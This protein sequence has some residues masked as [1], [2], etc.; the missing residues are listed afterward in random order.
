MDVALKDTIETNITPESS[1][2]IELL[3]GAAVIDLLLNPEFQKNIDRLFEACP[4]ATIFQNRLYITAWYQVYQKKHL[5]ILVKGEVNGHLIG[6]LPVVLLHTQESDKHKNSNRITGAG[7]YDAEYQTWLAI[8]VY[9]ELFIREAL[10]KLI[11][12]FP[13]NPISFRYLPPQ[14]PLNWVKDNNKWRSYSIVQ[15]HSRPLIKLSEPDHA[16]L[17]ESKQFKN[18]LNRLKRLGEVRLEPITDPESFKNHL[19]ELTVLYDFRFGALFNKQIFKDDPV[20]KEFLLELFRLQLLHA[21]ILKVNGEIFAAVIAIAGKGWLHLSGFTCHSPFKARSYSPGLLHFSFLAKKLREEQMQYLDLTPGYDSYK[22][23]LANM[24]DEVHELVIS[25]QFTYR[26]KKRIKKWVQV[27]LIT[28]GIR[29]MT[30]EL[31]LK[32]YFYLL[33]NSNIKTVLKKISKKL[34]SNTLQKRYELKAQTFR[35]DVKISLQKNNLDHLMKYTG[36]K[37]TGI[38]RWEFLADAMRRLETGQFCYTWAENNQLL[39]CAWFNTFDNEIE[40][41]DLYFYTKDRDKLQSFFFNLID[42]VASEKSSTGFH[43][44]N[45]FIC[46]AME[47]MGL[48]AEVSPPVKNNNFAK[49]FLQILYIICEWFTGSNMIT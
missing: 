46:E 30:A 44:N 24:H 41:K 9:G 14:T 40:L 8:P 15:L 17:L 13:G 7:H 6:V 12:Q 19:N 25:R 4:W 27:K 3:T 33:K 49:N 26:I 21:T 10:G 22:D 47:T 11:K 18:K 23:K 38:T 48:H 35:P 39:S 32:K 16:K 36:S 20:K 29:P 43:T 37:E 31:K 45:K 42:H 2:S 34:R 5:P 28:A 1:Y